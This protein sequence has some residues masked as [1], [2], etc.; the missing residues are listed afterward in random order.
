MPQTDCSLI[1][2][3]F[4]RI[5]D[6]DGK[7]I[8]VYKT[9]IVTIQRCCEDYAGNDCNKTIC[10]GLTCA[11]DSNAICGVINRCGVKFPVFFDQDGSVSTVCSQTELAKANLC[12]DE[13]CHANSTC[14]STNRQPVCLGTGLTCDCSPQEIWFERSGEVADCK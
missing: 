12:P 4:R 6:A 10:A 8:F 7:F 11:E 5:R 14:R 13:T 9:K 1:L 2:D 3:H